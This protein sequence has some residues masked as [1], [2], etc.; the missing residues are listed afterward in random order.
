M[1]QLDALRAFAITGVLLH[2]FVPG[3]IAYFPFGAAGVKLFFVLSGFLITNILLR[4]R[5]E[6][7]SGAATAKDRIWTFY[8]RRFLR[9]FP[10]Y[11]LVLA[12]ALA[13]GTPPAWE[14]FW[15]HAL[16]LTNVY[17]AATGDWPGH[18]SPFWTL[19][20]EE[21]F[22]LFWPWVVMF[23]PRRRLGVVCL[24]MIL[25]AVGVRAVGYWA[26]ANPG[27]VGVLPFA[28][29]DTLCLGALL[30]LASR[31]SREGN[32]DLLPRVGLWLGVP[33]TAGLVGLPHAPELGWVR[34]VFQDTTIG[35]VATWLVARAANGFRGTAG[36]LLELPAITRIGLIS[37]GIYVFHS[38]VPE[39][40]FAW[41]NAASATVKVTVAAAG[42][43]LLTLRLVRPAVR[44]G[45]LRR[46]VV[47]DLRPIVLNGLTTAALIACS[48]AS[49]RSGFLSV[50]GIGAFNRFVLSVAL[51]V[52]A[53]E[54]SWQVFET[55]L[56]RLKRLDPGR[57][58]GG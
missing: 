43:S 13:D 40:A 33:L 26:G 23:S 19:A 50:G 16:Y 11:Y 18:L 30:A 51:S 56:S 36:R 4:Y 6:V 58:G 22:Y 20:V 41:W 55:P 34:V 38:F 1:A 37:Y 12:I 14:T 48:Y 28:C 3:S 27:R 17:I 49:M 25:T 44:L 32:A 42:A 46:G 57:P 15:W 39:M 45:T 9:I 2:H 52:L 47:L 29:L 31:G 5:E 53:A 54:V 10:L 35:L 8:R 7:E 21:Q 24:G